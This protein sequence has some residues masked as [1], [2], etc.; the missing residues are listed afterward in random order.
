MPTI[1]QL[2]PEVD[3]LLRLAPEEVAKALLTSASSMAQNGMFSSGGVIGPDSLFG[4]G[5]ARTV[6][7]P[8]ERVREIEEALGVAWL[9]LEIN[10]FF[11]PVPGVNGQNV[12]SL[13]SRMQSRV[14][15][16]SPLVW[17]RA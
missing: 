12:I 1:P 5:D 10:L 14:C 15:P 8:R 2:I 9:W 3:A 6:V 7:Y 16:D 17:M 13:N 11:M 4:R